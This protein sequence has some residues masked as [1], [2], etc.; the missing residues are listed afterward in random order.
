MAMALAGFILALHLFG[1]IGSYSLLSILETNRNALIYDGLSLQNSKGIG[2]HLISSS[3]NHVLVKHCSRRS[4]GL[5]V[6]Q[7]T[8]NIYYFLNILLLLVSNDVQRN[9]GPTSGSN[10]LRIS[11]F[12]ARSI[13]N[14]RLDLEAYVTLVNADF[15]A[16]TETWL[17][18]NIDDNEL[19]PSSYNIHR[20][21]RERR[22]GGVLL[23]V[24]SN[25][26]CFRC[27]DLEESYCELL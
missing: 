2:I 7:Y 12:N 25:I 3:R 22:G 26:S 13:V 4:C 23:A 20:K 11:S 21:D 17:H 5:R 16:I 6:G 14:K 18:N 24:K 10:A 9:P 8:S 15:I 19:L 27:R 1:F